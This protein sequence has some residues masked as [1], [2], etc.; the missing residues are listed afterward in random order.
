MKYEIYQ[1]KDAKLNELAFRPYEPTLRPVL[2]ENYDLVWSGEVPGTDRPVAA[3]EDIFRQFNLDHPAGFKGR[4]LSVSDVVIF[5]EWSRD[6]QAGWFCNMT[7]WIGWE[8]K[9]GW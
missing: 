3:L 9:T 2:R 4:S 1:V 6:V 5:P 8:S 7:G